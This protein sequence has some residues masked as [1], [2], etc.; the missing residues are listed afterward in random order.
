LQH[1]KSQYAALFPTLTNAFPTIF[2]ARFYTW[3]AFLWAA[4]LW[5]SY[6]LK[7]QFPDGRIRTALVPLVSL[8]NHAVSFHTLNFIIEQVVNT[9]PP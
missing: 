2:P 4:E 9:S 6:G 3:A 5:Y 7:V 8:L 1:L